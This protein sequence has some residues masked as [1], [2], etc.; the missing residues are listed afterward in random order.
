MNSA[1]PVSEILHNLSG[2]CGPLYL[3]W[4]FRFVSI[5]PR[6][7]ARA[8]PHYRNSS[9]SWLRSTHCHLKRLR[10]P[11]ASSLP[12]AALTHP[13]V[14]AKWHRHG[15]FLRQLTQGKTVH[16]HYNTHSVSIH[17]RLLLPSGITIQQPTLQFSTRLSST[18]TVFHVLNRGIHCHSSRLIR[19]MSSPQDR[20]ATRVDRP[21]KQ[22]RISQA[23]TFN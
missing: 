20:A 1:L 11:S 3:I 8:C 4:G 7:R 21:R 13:R 6:A 9:R 17:L 15:R 23:C 5:R 10:G 14:C 12:F 18:R 16:R 2:Q 19:C 22:Q